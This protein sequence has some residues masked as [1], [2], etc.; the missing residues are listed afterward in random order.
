MKSSSLTITALNK[1]LLDI[2]QQI[3]ENLTQNLDLK[4]ES[5]LLNLF[6]QHTSCALTINEAY[7]PLAA[8]DLGEF[9]EHLAPTNL[10]F[11]KHTDEGP[12]DCPSHMKALITGHSLTIPVFKGHL[13]LGR[14]QGIFLCEFRDTPRPRTILSSFIS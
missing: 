14:W 5:G 10:T 13:Q 7:D 9:L 8:N 3:K 2:T 4:E 12:D 1:G 6:I 11:I